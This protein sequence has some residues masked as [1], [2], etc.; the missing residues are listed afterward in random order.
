MRPRSW[1]SFNVVAGVGAGIHNWKVSLRRAIRICLGV[2]LGL[3]LLVVGVAG[4]LWWYFH[5]SVQRT[6]AVVYGQRGDHKLM[7]DVIHPAEPNGLGVLVMVSGGWKSGKANSFKE[8]GNAA[9][10]TWV[11]GIRGLPRLAA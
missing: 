11:Y 8:C 2:V 1:A 3:L 10:T 4:G 9:L 5:P 7:L 6:N